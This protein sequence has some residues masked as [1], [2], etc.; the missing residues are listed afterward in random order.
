M[1]NEYG[2]FEMICTISTLIFL[3]V[4]LCDGLSDHTHV[5]EECEYE[6]DQHFNNYGIRLNVQDCIK[7]KIE[8]NSPTNSYYAIS[9]MASISTKKESDDQLV[10]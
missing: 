8:L 4:M 10:K 6:S 5:V 3:V 9:S 2:I 7:N 1:K